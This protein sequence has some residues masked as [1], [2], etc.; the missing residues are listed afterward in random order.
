MI[1]LPVCLSA[2]STFSA[3]HFH[4]FHG[5]NQHISSVFRI[6]E[7]RIVPELLHCH[8]TLQKIYSKSPLNSTTN[9]DQK[10]APTVEHCMSLLTKL[11]FSQT[12]CIAPLVSK[13]LGIL[14]L[15][16]AVGLKLPQII[17]IY[18][19]MDVEGLSPTSFYSEVPLVMSNVAYNYL[20]GNPFSSYGENVF[21]LIQNLILVMLLWAYMKQ[22]PT[23][24]HMITILAF[25][26]AVGVGSVHL[27]QKYQ[28]LLPM[29]SLPLLLASRIPQIIQ[30]FQN[31]S[32]GSLS[33]ITNFLTF[34]GSLARVFTTIQEVGMDYSLLVGFFLGCSTSGI[35]LLQVR[36][37]RVI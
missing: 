26:V 18:Q 10:M 25:F 2:S 7:R 29:S 6:Q 35:L 21:I 15:V 14:I 31:Q 16:G 28:Y 13:L 12:D 11:D 5:G 1:S 30:N 27:P 17:G 20:Q 32:T 8:T 3:T 9:N 4:D 34:A 19:T 33:L 36:Q 22:K 23:V 24:N 37:C